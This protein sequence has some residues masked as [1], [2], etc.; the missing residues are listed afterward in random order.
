M[1]GL[2]YF[3]QRWW[4]KKFSPLF[5][6]GTKNARAA[7]REDDYRRF[8]LA[9]AVAAYGLSQKRRAP[10]LIYSTSIDTDQ[11]FAVRVLKGRRP[12]ARYDVTVDR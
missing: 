3:I 8:A 1:I 12:I 11:S 10:K 6:V 4:Y 5:R 2:G 7:L 9:L